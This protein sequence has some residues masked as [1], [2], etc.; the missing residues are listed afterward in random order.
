MPSHTPSERRRR[1]NPFSEVGR[2]QDFTREGIIASGELLRPEI[3]GRIGDTLGGLN[4]IGALRSG[5]T[6]VALRDISREFTDRFGQIASRAT[7]GAIGFGLEAKGL[8]LRRR[9]RK[10][11]RRAALASAVGGVIGAGAGFALNR[12]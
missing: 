5:G 8:K 7:L 9:E 11:Q 4:S 1:F 10:S 3:L 2:A 6:E 12:G